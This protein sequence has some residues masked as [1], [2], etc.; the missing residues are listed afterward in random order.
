MHAGQQGAAEQQVS[1]QKHG[2]LFGK[3]ILAWCYSF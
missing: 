1:K 3:L 2:D